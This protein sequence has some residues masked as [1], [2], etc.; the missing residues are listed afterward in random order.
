MHRE[1]PKSFPEAA[2]GAQIRRILSALVAVLLLTAAV[3]ALWMRLPAPAP[4]ASASWIDFRTSDVGAALTV[5]ALLAALLPPAVPTL[6][7]LL[8]AAGATAGL[9][10][11]V[12]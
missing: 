5:R 10:R 3:A 4:P 11:I 9:R 7:V 6:G 2:E 12:R 8:L 1:L